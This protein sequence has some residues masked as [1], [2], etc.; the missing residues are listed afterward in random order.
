MYQVTFADQGLKALQKLPMQEQLHT[1]EV[2][3]SL[4]PGTLHTDNVGKFDRDGTTFYRLRVDTWRIYF[5]VESQN[6]LKIY[7]MV[8]QHSLTD[9]IFRFKLPVSEEQ[10]IE[11]HS[12]FWKYLESL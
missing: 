2:L 10:M 6:I 1:I 5:C 7:Y 12:S 4:T 8:P 9:F 11:Q 3:G